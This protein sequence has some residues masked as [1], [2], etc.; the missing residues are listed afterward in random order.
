MIHSAV[1]TSGYGRGRGGYFSIGD[2]S[3]PPSYAGGLENGA[4][5][6]LGL[7]RLAWP[8][9]RSFAFLAL[10]GNHLH[11]LRCRLMEDGRHREIA[12][13]LTG[14]GLPLSKCEAYNRVYD[15][16]SESH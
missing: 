4:A 14:H 8:P 5:K 1:E 2:G 13:E 9:Q 12:P 16:S 11:R 10:I 6:Y 15:Q 7:A 3:Q